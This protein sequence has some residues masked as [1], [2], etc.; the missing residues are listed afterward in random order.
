[1]DVS[2]ASY[3]LGSEPT[4]L[5]RL[6][7]Q[8]RAL[9]P[10]TRALLRAAGIRP[11]MRVLDLGSGAGDVSFL[12][13][14]L[15]GPNGKV[16]GV[17]QSADAIALAEARAR[18]RLVSNVRFV[19]GDIHEPASGGPFD[20][21]VG[22]MVLM[23]A[24]DPPAVLRT[25][26]E[27]L[28]PGGVVAPVE[29]DMWAAGSRPDTPLVSHTVSWLIEAFDQA[30]APTAL[31]PALVEVL[32]KA[33]LR[34]LGMLGVHPQFVPDDPDGPALFAGIVRTMLPL[35]EKAGAATAQ[36]IQPETFEARLAGELIAANAVLAYPELFCAW[37]TRE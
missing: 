22:R 36:E 4:E 35:I 10:A 7:L 20:A 28:R 26:A 27:L 32:R 5:E 9:E 11:G 23:Y 13:A 29:M 30:N 16:I 33:G 6:A 24:P 3:Q 2:R 18:Q 34:P 1:M 8:G 31:G 17:E 15:V 14:E 37:G 19:Q 12:V 21:I 25:Q